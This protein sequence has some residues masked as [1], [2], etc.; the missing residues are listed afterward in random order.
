[1][2]RSILGAVLA[3][4]LIGTGCEKKNEQARN[5]PSAES[6]KETIDK[7]AK[8]ATE[9]IDAQA[10][11]EKQRIES[12]AAAAKS[13]LDAQQAQAKADASQLGTNVAAERQ[14]I[15][16]AAGGASTNTGVESGSGQSQLP[17]ALQESSSNSLTQQVA[18]VISR[19]A[20]ETQAAAA[21]IQ[22]EESDGTVTLRGSVPTKEAKATAESAAKSVRGVKKVKNELE[23]RKQ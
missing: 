18:E 7:A 5:N 17:S 11:A 8:K 16:E 19:N 23:V 10:K 15:R 3:V 20:R 14:I 9:K 21:G 6:K 22:V 4:A 13:Q 12:E 2:T 1:M